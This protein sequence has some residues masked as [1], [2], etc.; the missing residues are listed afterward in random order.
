MTLAKDGTS[1]SGLNRLAF[2]NFLRALEHSITGLTIQELSESSGL[3]IN[4]IAAWIKS[5]HQKDTPAHLRRKVVY[6]SEY[7]RRHCY[8]TA[9][10]KLG[11][12]PDAIKPAP[13]TKALL[14]REFRAQRAKKKEAALGLDKP[15]KR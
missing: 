11:S 3:S 9:R 4:C 5:M 13:K 1:H 10:Y 6:I 8:W 14:A 2:V 7:V 15:R 12:C